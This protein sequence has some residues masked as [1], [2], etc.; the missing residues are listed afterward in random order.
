MKVQQIITRALRRI[1]TIGA[2]QTPNSND[3]EDALDTLKSLYQRWITEGAFGTLHDVIAPSGD[4]I[5]H[6]NTRVYRNDESTTSILLPETVE[7]K[8]GY[9]VDYL[10]YTNDLCYNRKQRLP[11]DGSIIVVIDSFTTGAITYIYDA[12][13]KRWSDITTI[14]LGDNAPLSERDS[15]GL[16]A[17]LAVELADEFGAT[18][19]PTTVNS[20][21][22][23]QMGLTQNYSFE[24][25][26]TRVSYI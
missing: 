1:G 26:Y 11:R 17:C 9:G 5:A 3:N 12:S 23:F 15:S 20:A 21:I 16:A 19:P 4:Y 8:E 2:G 14:D 24:S 25:E 10:N 13:I 22:R 6:E 18:A 7:N